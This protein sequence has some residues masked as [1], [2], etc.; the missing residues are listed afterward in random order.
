MNKKDIIDLTKD[1][2]EVYEPSILDSSDTVKEIFKEFCD[3][4]N[5]IIDNN[6]N[7]KEI[8]EA[9][10]ISEVWRK[11]FK[12][13]LLQIINERET[14]A[15]T[16]WNFDISKFKTWTIGVDMGLSKHDKQKI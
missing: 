6:M 10:I 7:D 4:M 5:I 13:S 14:E 8:K 15:E 9:R 1:M 3:I 16:K 11:N 2:K 12:D